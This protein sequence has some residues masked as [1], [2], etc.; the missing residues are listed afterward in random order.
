MWSVIFFKND[1]RGR[2]TG[3][4][5]G[6]RYTV[7][8]RFEPA[9]LLSRYGKFRVCSHV[10]KVNFGR[11]SASG[12]RKAYMYTYIYES[13]H[14]RNITLVHSRARHRPLLQLCNSSTRDPRTYQP[15][16][17]DFS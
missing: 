4:K 13:E 1:S 14:A 2:R 17:E 11:P 3:K 8:E 16:E 15:G 5:G 12:K 10:T 7:K 6:S 9:G